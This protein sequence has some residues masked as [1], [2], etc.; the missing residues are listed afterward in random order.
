MIHKTAYDA[1]HW[2]VTK[3]LIT[4]QMLQR[5]LIALA[6]IKANNT[7]ENLNIKSGKSYKSYVLCISKRSYWKS[8]QQYNEYDKAIKQNRHHIY[9][10]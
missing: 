4:K 10:L 8:M 2:K 1:K 6:Q 9:E 3:L 5:L 7:S